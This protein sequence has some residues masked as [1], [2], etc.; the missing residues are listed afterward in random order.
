MKRRIIFDSAEYRIFDKNRNKNKDR[1]SDRNLI[2]EYGMSRKVKENAE[3]IIM[4]L[5]YKDR[6]QI[7]SKL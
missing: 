2:G 4:K 6:K 3:D 1:N 7:K 5:K